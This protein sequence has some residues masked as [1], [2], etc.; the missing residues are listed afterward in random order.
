MKS[1]FTLLVL[2]LWSLSTQAQE[3]NWKQTFLDDFHKVKEMVIS[4]HPGMGDSSN[5]AFKQWAEKDDAFWDSW[6]IDSEAAYYWALAY[7]V[8]GLGDPHTTA[9]IGTTGRGTKEWP[10]FFMVYTG[11]K[12]AT[13]SDFASNPV[14]AQDIPPNGSELIECEG[15]TPDALIEKNTIGFREVSGQNA[16]V[17]RLKFAPRLFT[18]TDNPYEKWPSECTFKTAEDKIIRHQIKWYPVEPVGKELRALLR[19]REFNPNYDFNKRGNAYW[20]GMHTFNFDDKLMEVS[21][22]IAEQLK[23]L[24]LKNA[25]TENDYFV[26]DLRGNTGGLYDVSSLEVLFGE[27]VFQYLNL[28]NWKTW[29]YLPS[30]YFIQSSKRQKDEADKNA[31]KEAS[32]YYAQQIEEAETARKEGHSYFHI[33]EMPES[34]PFANPKFS[35]VNGKAPKIYVVI[36]RMCVSSCL[37]FLDGLSNYP[38]VTLVGE[39]SGFDQPYMPVMGSPLALKPEGLSLVMPFGFISGRKRGHNESYVPDFMIDPSRLNSMSDE[40]LAKEIEKIR[41]SRP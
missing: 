39:P 4:S 10:G 14:N 36:D 32:E 7:Y 25:F 2:F 28:G 38:N 27:G 19:G 33:G 11:T 31:N 20:I 5:P 29:A 12:F 9:R 26:F 16:M 23:D 30:N 13:H 18:K 1:L 8:N 40:E 34:L 21:S 37:L 3:V 15:S 41:E 35:L 6:K 22:K 17:T 24:K